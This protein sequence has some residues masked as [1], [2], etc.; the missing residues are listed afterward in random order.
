MFAR[1]WVAVLLLGAAVGTAEAQGNAGAKGFFLGAALNGSTLS[2]DDLDEE[3][4]SGGG[5]FLQLGWGFT[6]Q[7]ALFLEGSGAAMQSD[8]ESWLFSH[9]DLGLRYHF[10]GAG[11]RF[12]PF[13]DGGFTAWSGL[14]DDAQLGNQTG[15]LE[16]SGAG[17]TVGAGF[18]YF[19]TSRMALNTQLK[20]TKG[21]FNE[22]R[23]EN[24]SVEGLDIDATSGRFNI[25]LTWFLGGRR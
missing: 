22:V 20:F 9:G 8:G 4:E 1:H 3:S 17:F 7:L 13:V 24:V 11:R 6:P 25:G 10:A 14:Q 5:L 19:F 15:E 2:A 23:F 18:L 16:I 21:E 12:V